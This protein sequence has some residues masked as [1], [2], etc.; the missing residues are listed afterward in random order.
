MRNLPSRSKGVGPGLK[1]WG[2][3]K[4]SST[5][6]TSSIKQKEGS[7][8]MGLIEGCCCCCWFESKKKVRRL[9][10]WVRA[11]LRR[12]MKT[13][14]KKKKRFCS[15]HYDPLS[16]SLNFDDGNFGFFC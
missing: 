10:W 1:L 12:L 9:F 16:Y 3:E 7:T 2:I 13:R 6:P 5:H 15:F 4:C 11:E 14:T 8:S